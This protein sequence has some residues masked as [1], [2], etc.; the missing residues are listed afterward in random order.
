MMKFVILCFSLSNTLVEGSTNLFDGYKKRSGLIADVP[1]AIL[2]N[3]VE[4]PLVGLGV[5]NLQSDRVENMIYEGL[6]G[7]NRIRLFD[8]SQVAGVDNE[9]IQ[10]IKSGTKRFKE[11]DG[12]DDRVQVHLVTKIRHTYLGYERTKFAVK[13][14]LQTYSPVL[15]DSNIDFRIHFLIHH[16]RCIDSVDGM[17]CEKDEDELP[18]KV[19]RVGSAP[20]LGDGD[21]WK[22]SWRALEDLY[23]SDDY[24]AISS[25]GVS[26]FSVEE[27]DELLGLSRVKPHLVQMNISSLIEDTTLVDRCKMHDTHIVVFNVMEHI[28]M[29]AAGTPRAFKSV[30][31]TGDALSNGRNAA[32]PGQIILKWLTQNGISIIPRTHDLDHLSENSVGALARLSDI[33]SNA[34]IVLQKAVEAIHMGV[35]LDEDP[36][37]QMSFYASDGDIF[38]YRYKENL[39]DQTYVAYVGKGNSAKIWVNPNDTFRVY[40]AY[41]P[42]LFKDYVLLEH[43]GDDR[44]IAVG[45]L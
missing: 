18:G 34:N 35:D 8:T 45:S 14:I 44:H 13:S 40:N 12:I 2:S 33:S 11:A 10:G 1:A 4:F 28:V 27:M 32:N 3:E 41:D 20:H 25:I 21:A 43:D 42:K 9:I 15:K 39:A 22:E 17:D 24:P 38:L 23:S 26:N 31:L 7:E 36:R 29:R 6:K 16:P 30:A 37:V 19:K 5:G